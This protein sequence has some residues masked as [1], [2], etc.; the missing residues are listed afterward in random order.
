MRDIPYSAAFKVKDV[1]VFNTERIA[2]DVTLAMPIKVVI[3][4]APRACVITKR[5]LRT[6]RVH[7]S[8]SRSM[9]VTVSG[10][11]TRAPN[12]LI[13]FLHMLAGLRHPGVGSLST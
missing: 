8:A 2:C 1:R 13:E 12:G 3:G 7:C 5:S 4:T 10:P 11:V 9:L 6:M